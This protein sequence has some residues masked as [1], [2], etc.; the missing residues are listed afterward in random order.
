MYEFSS[1][2]GGYGTL[3]LVKIPVIEHHLDFVKKKILPEG[4]KIEHLA[5]ISE[6]FVYFLSFESFFLRV[7]KLTDD[8]KT[9]K[10]SKFFPTKFLK[11]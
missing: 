10:L 9:P 2:K 5:K 3:F 4:S 11:T 6:M 1:R 8:N 7:S